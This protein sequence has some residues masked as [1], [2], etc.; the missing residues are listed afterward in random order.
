[1]DPGQPE[2]PRPVSFPF[3][4]EQT[5]Q[6]L[7]SGLSLDKDPRSAQMVGEI[8]GQHPLMPFQAITL[9]T[10]TVFGSIMN[11][12][13]D[14]ATTVLI[15]LKAANTYRDRKV[16]AQRIDSQTKGMAI[17]LQAFNLESNQSL[18]ESLS[19][20]GVEELE[21]IRQTL[22]ETLMPA[23]GAADV[24]LLE[25]LLNSPRISEHQV[26]L[27]NCLTRASENEGSGYPKEF[28]NGGVA[29]Y[30]ILSQVWPKL[31]PHFK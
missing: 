3:I 17:V 31:A 23:E 18:F 29:M 12:N 28:V 25:G 22:R 11:Y 9:L 7:L 19:H 4:S 30:K 24:S 6:T 26:N 27:N 21:N 5:R 15:G 13:S 8:S 14:F 20:L 2:A 10:E 16:N 1:M